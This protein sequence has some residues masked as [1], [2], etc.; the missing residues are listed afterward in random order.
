MKRF[1]NSYL[2]LIALLLSIALTAHATTYYDWNAS[3]TI[4]AE[5]DDTPPAPTPPTPLYEMPAVPFSKTVASSSAF[6][7]SAEVETTEASHVIIRAADN[8]YL[9]GSVATPTLGILIPKDTV[10]VLPFGSAMTLVTSTDTVSLQLL[11]V[12]YRDSTIRR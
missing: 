9:N 4:P 2:L 5:T 3:G 12:D 8:L 1:S 10:V 7:I 6:S 11:P